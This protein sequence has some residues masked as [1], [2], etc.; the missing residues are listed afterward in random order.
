[1]IVELSDFLYVLSAAAF[2]TLLR[3]NKWFGLT[4]GAKKQR[5]GNVQII[6]VAICLSSWSRSLARKT[7]RFELSIY[8]TLK[9]Q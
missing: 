5:V 2:L 4:F 3:R 6:D 8:L 7:P 1:M 9:T